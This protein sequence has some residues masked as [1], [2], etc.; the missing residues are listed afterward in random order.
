MT[1]VDWPERY[2]CIVELLR[3]QAGLSFAPSERDVVKHAIRRTMQSAGCT[4]TGDYANL[5]NS[6]AE[7]LDV[8]LATITG[9]ETRFFRDAGQFRIIS[10]LILPDIRRRRG[11][12]HTIRFW[13]AGCGSGEEVYSLAMILHRSGAL[14]NADVL[15]SDISAQALERAR[16]AVYPDSSLGGENPEL[17]MSYLTQKDG[18]HHVSAA[19]KKSVRFEFLNLALDNYPSVASGT[20]GMD[21][22]MCRNVLSYF[23]EDTMHTVVQRLFRSLAEGGWLITSPADPP[24]YEFEMFDFIPTED[25]LAYRKAN[26]SSAAATPSADDS[27]TSLGENAGSLGENAGS[28]GENAGSFA[29]S[30]GVSSES[31]GSRS[32]G[33]GALGE[34]TASVGASASSLRGSTAAAGERTAP[35]SQDAVSRSDN[36]QTLGATRTPRPATR[37]TP[38]NETARASAPLAEAR[39]SSERTVKTPEAV[40]AANAARTAN[41]TAR[42]KL[43]PTAVA[44]T[45]AMA[46]A[47]L[48]TRDAS[49][50]ASP[51]RNRILADARQALAD[52]DFPRAAE[53]TND[54]RGDGAIIHIKAMAGIDVALAAKACEVATN[55]RPLSQELRYLYAILLIELDRCDEA[56]EALQR[57]LYLDQSLARAHYSLGAVLVSLGDIDGAKQSFHATLEICDRSSPDQP[58]PLGDNETVRELRSKT[59]SQ[60][61]AIE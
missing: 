54:L 46:A 58:V 24:I 23:D 39:P 43:A 6:N 41:P 55:K 20:R 34:S 56:V 45:V 50:F 33:V 52:G 2:K 7:A 42:A 9:G 36:T 1:E 4:N 15:G 59:R 35:L 40:P 61:G 17:A 37:R 38:S 3:Q 16:E 30:A 22:I 14:S 11:P 27:A 26:M 18:K 29:V 5:L 53:L 28:L 8:L 44:G 51:S 25:G 49:N 31:A 13:S 48:K 10:D 57:V 19:I 12:G 21:L 47:G 60:L 32:E